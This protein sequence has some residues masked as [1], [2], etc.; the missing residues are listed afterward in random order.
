[1]NTAVIKII[2]YSFVALGLLVLLLFLL[3]SNWV[4][5]I[6]NFN[7]ISVNGVNYANADKYSIGNTEVEASQVTTLDISW[8]SGSLEVIPYDGSKIV[9]S[10]S[11]TASLQDEERLHYWHD[12]NTLNIK[13]CASGLGKIVFNTDKKALQIKVPK[14][15]AAHLKIKTASASCNISA[16]SA[17]EVDINTA[18][19]SVYGKING[20]VDNA[21]VH[22]VS[23]KID[24]SC[25]TDKVDLSSVSGDIE[26]NGVA[27][28]VDTKT[29]S[30]AIRI[31]TENSPERIKASSV[32]GSVK[33]YLPETAEFDAQLSTVS[34]SIRCEFPTVT[35]SKNNLKCGNGDIDI[36][37]STVSGNLYINKR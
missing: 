27:T 3:K 25:K 7:G 15:Y 37:A 4:K 22:T 21:K 6:P 24:F 2:T 33:V 16:I 1:M 30:G 8:I 5:N 19:G 32:S 12:G 9:V 11:N 20:T 18:S 26:F 31:N 35:L 13:F 14:E 23:G 10:E 17:T 28:K 36:E 34:G 29:T